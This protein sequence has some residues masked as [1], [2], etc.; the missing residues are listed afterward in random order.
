MK[1]SLDVL[2]ISENEKVHFNFKGI[3]LSDDALLNRNSSN[4]PLM[5]MHI[6]TY[7]FFRQGKLF[8]GHNEYEKAFIT[9]KVVNLE[10]AHF[11]D[12]TLMYKTSH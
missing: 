6:H 3:V 5:Y 9:L 11:L 1:F 4:F 10:L 12:G 8:S 2:L 7:A